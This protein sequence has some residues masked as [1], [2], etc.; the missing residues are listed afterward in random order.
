M[1]KKMGIPGASDATAF[2]Q[3]ISDFDDIHEISIVEMAASALKAQGAYRRRGPVGMKTHHIAL[4]VR[5]RVEGDG[6]PSREFELLSAHIAPNEEAMKV[7]LFSANL[8]RLS[9][10]AEE[11]AR[12]F[13]HIA[14]FLVVCEYHCFLG[15]PHL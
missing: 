11:L 14:S 3:A 4:N 9:S 7:P 2:Q 13:D 12:D 5:R 6:N 8:A 10:R 1:A 15:S